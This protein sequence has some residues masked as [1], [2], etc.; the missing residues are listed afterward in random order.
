MLVS[1]SLSSSSTFFVTNQIIIIY[2][3]LNVHSFSCWSSLSL[4]LFEMITCKNVWAADLNMLDAKT[5]WVIWIFMW[6]LCSFNV[7][8]VILELSAFK[9]I[10]IIFNASVNSDEIS[11]KLIAIVFN[12]SID[13][14][15]TLIMK[16][17]DFEMLIKTL[18]FDDLVRIMSKWVNQRKSELNSA[19]SLEIVITKY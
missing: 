2:K 8:D 7:C 11:I 6:A 10:M 4:F 9:L 15:E 3:V 14:D 12:A 1:E 19:W 5:F 17:S 16:A 18:F 13:S